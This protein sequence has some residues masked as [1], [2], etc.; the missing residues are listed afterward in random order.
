MITKPSWVT[1]TPIIR[2]CFSYFYNHDLANA[3]IHNASVRYSPI[4]FRLAE[5]LSDIGE[6]TAVGVAFDMQV[7]AVLEDKGKYDEDKG[8]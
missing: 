2:Q 4:T 7:M 5:L 1:A 6:A 8:R 3:A